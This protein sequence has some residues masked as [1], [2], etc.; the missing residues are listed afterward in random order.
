LNIPEIR[1]AATKAGHLWVNMGG[2]SGIA[3][4]ILLLCDR[5]DA[6]QKMRDLLDVDVEQAKK[7]W[8]T[9]LGE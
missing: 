4:V 8:D 7:E 6:G 3:K 9:Q 1:I 2:F 5:A